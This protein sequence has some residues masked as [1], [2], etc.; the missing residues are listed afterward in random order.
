MC[1]KAELISTRLLSIEDKRDMLNGLLPDKALL[2]HVKCWIEAGMPN[3]NSSE[4]ALYSNAKTLGVKRYY[5][6]NDS[7]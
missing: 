6:P 2:L 1:V 7:G 3:Y 4:I 5:R